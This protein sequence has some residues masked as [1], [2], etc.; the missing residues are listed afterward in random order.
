MQRFMH[1]LDNLPGLRSKSRPVQAL[2]AVYYG[3]LALLLFGGLV[4]GLMSF[5]TS[6]LFAALF[7]LP[8][9]AYAKRRSIPLVGG[10]TGGQKALGWILAF[11]VWVGMAGLVTSVLPDA[12]AA[13]Q[14]LMEAPSVVETEEPTTEP[15]EPVSSDTPLAPATSTPKPAPTT[16]APTDTSEPPSATP[17]PTAIPPTPIPPTQPPPVDLDPRTD[18]NCNEFGSSEQLQAWRAYWIARGVSNPGRLDGD[19]DGIGCEDGE[20]GRPA[21]VPQPVVP[22]PAAPQPPPPPARG[23]CCKTC[24]AG[25]ACGDTCISRDKTCQQPPGCACDG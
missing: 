13:P 16:P 2:A 20:G 5:F 4:G 10:E 7:T 23:P 18:R 17:Q 22:P 19:G 6:I 3:F 12:P 8:V 9:V 1:L 24:R 11:I 21:A 15:P 25:K 14:P